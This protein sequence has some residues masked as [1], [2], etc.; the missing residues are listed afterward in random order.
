MWKWLIK[1][2]ISKARQ[3]AG[4]FSVNHRFRGFYFRFLAFFEG[5]GYDEANQ[6][7]RRNRYEYDG[8]NHFHTA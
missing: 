4:F 3:T 8:R 1:F 7:N 2:E 5:N 6:I